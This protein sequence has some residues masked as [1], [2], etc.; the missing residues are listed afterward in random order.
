M[1]RD[2]SEKD[3]AFARTLVKDA[4]TSQKSISNGSSKLDDV[5]NSS[6]E[7]TEFNYFKKSAIA[8]QLNQKDKV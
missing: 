6:N 2:L 7:P 8:A 1:E 3:L 4:L 5:D